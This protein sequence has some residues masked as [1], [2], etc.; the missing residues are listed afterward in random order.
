M[1]V[2]RYVV[3]PDGSRLGVELVGTG[4]RVLFVHGG[5][6]DRTRWDRITE[7][8]RGALTMCLLDR[9][10][11]GLSRDEATGTYTWRREAAD[12]AAVAEALGARAVVGH[13]YGGLC[14]LGATHLTSEI[15][16]AVVYEPTLAAPGI[17]IIPA[18]VM[19]RIGTLLDGDRAD[20]ALSLFFTDVVGV[21]T[22][23]V[24]Q[25]R[26]TAD[27]RARLAAL[28]TALREGAAVAAVDVDAL[29]LEEIGLPVAVLVGS[30]TTAPLAAAARAV[31]ARL[32]QGRLVELAGSGHTAMDDDPLVFAS[33][34]LD[35]L[36]VAKV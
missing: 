17:P 1:A 29:A 4:P 11:R 12:V 7:P 2:T 26:Q 8:L 32:P 30:T 35:T 21:P 9:R 6:A 24:A 5:T 34:L 28:P 3:S 14:A 16:R 10:G 22:A 19:E 20:D 18:G 36:G 15:D 13:S 33:V 25:R 23:D 27:W 31:A